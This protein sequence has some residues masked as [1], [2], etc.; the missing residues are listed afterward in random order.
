MSYVAEQDILYFLFSLFKAP[1]HFPGFGFRQQICFTEHK[2]R[3][4]VGI[5]AYDQVSLKPV[6]IEIIVYCLDDKG[7]IDIGRYDLYFSG[8][9]GCLSCQD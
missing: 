7:N 8:L 6:D 9:A 3:F 1:D 5:V 4:N 2:N